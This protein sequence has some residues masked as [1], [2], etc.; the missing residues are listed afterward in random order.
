[1]TPHQTTDLSLHLQAISVACAGAAATR[2]NPK[3]VAS[4]RTH[5][6]PKETPAEG[7]AAFFWRREAS[8][9]LLAMASAARSERLAR[10]LWNLQADAGALSMMPFADPSF[11]EL[12][13]TLNG[14]I[15]DAIEASDPSAAKA[16]MKDLSTAGNEWLLAKHARGGNAWPASDGTGIVCMHCASGVTSKAA[17]SLTLAAA[18]TAICNPS[19]GRCWCRG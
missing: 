11:C 18:A 16:R 6:R 19:P 3:D 13:A 9:F 12:T 4:M 7:D 8:E 2:A 10:E 14:L 1:M 5:I 17:H 15:T